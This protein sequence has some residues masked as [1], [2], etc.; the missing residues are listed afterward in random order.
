MAIRLDKFLAKSYPKY[1]RNKLNQFI[2]TGYVY[3]NGYVEQK[4]SYLV[5]PSDEIK[6]EINENN[7]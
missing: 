4:P 3:V 1:S 6:L 2:E 7:I 5:K